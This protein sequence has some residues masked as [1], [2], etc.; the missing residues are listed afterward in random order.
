MASATSAPPTE[1]PPGELTLRTMALASGSASKRRNPARTSALSSK[2]S[3]MS[4]P[5]SGRY[6]RAPLISRTPMP[7]SM[8]VRGA[9]FWRILRHDSGSAAAGLRMR[10]NRACPARASSIGTCAASI[11]RT[12]FIAGGRNVVLCVLAEVLAGLATTLLRRVQ[13]EIRHDRLDGDVVLF[14]NPFRPV[15]D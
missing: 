6:A 9:K 15:E 12:L 2:P 3:K 13:T 10:L 14:G 1:K 8:L 7:P 5:R 4:S 11:I